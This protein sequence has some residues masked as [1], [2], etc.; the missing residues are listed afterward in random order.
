[1]STP[2]ATAPPVDEGAELLRRAERAARRRT[3]DTD[4]AVIALAVDEARVVIERTMWVGI[5]LGMVFTTASVQEWGAQAAPAWSI[6][7]LAAWLLA[8]LVEVPLL[9][10]LRGEQVAA[11]YGVRPGTWVR[12]AR[13][14]L[15]G[16]AYLMNSWGPWAGVFASNGADGWAKVLLHSIPPLAVL[17][18]AEALTDLRDMLTSAIASAASAP[19]SATATPR[20]VT[21]PR[22]PRTRPRPQTPPPVTPEPEVDTPEPPATGDGEP[23]APAV[24]TAREAAVAWAL[25]NWDGDHRDPRT[26]EPC[27]IRPLHVRAHMESIQRPISK[28]EASKVLTAAKAERFRLGLPTRS[29]DDREE[30]TG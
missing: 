7:W 28:G 1:M 25:E 9:A 27:E 16:A 22:E 4:P 2:T 23:P 10:I 8:P 29:G 17:I 26:G 30:E 18:A 3:Y 13:W 14:T 15:L 11:R 20:P 21:R 6:G 12:R 19:R 5:V 24:G